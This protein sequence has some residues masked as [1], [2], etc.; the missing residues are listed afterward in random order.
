MCLGRLQGRD[1]L[2]GV[3]AGHAGGAGSWPGPLRPLG[4][5]AAGLGLALKR[6]LNTNMHPM[7]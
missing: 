7:G 2:G 3:L 4:H 5:R 1:A 6:K